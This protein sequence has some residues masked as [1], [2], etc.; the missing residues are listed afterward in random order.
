MRYLLTAAAALA[1]CGILA[2]AANAQTFQP[3]GPLKV[4]NMCKVVTDSNTEI[5]A[6]GYYAPCAYQAQAQ[7]PARRNRR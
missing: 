5:E 7:A 1:A 2:T 3:G 4:S 6:Y